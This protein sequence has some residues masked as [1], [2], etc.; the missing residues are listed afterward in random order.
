MHPRILILVAL[1]RA[2]AEVATADGGLPA[3]CSDRATSN[4][5]ASVAPS[6]GNARCEY[7][8]D[9]LR[10]HFSLR[11]TAECYVDQRNARWPPVPSS[12]NKT[13]TGPYGGQVIVQGREGTKLKQRFS[14]HGGPPRPHPGMGPCLII[15]HLEI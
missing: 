12:K 2:R 4:Y 5:D 7:S 11:P 1:A 8:C 9:K 13:Y 10:K 3:G 6:A 14:L 15:R